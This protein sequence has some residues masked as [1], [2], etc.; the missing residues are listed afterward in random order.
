MCIRIST[1]SCSRSRHRQCRKTPAATA[2][3]AST[4]PGRWSAPSTAVDRSSSCGRSIATFTSAKDAS[5]LLLLLRGV[6]GFLEPR[7][8]EHIRHRVVAFVT[9]VL[10]QLLLACLPRILAGP[11]PIPRRRI[12][13][14]E[15][16]EER[17][18]VDALDAFDDVQLIA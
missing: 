4:G 6:L 16:I 11:R 2:A 13:D 3:I 15:A 12:L 7:A 8:S 1:C 14:G 17:V 10:V 5:P 9:G 18:R